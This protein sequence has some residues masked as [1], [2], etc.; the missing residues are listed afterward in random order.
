MIPNA[1]INKLDKQLIKNKIEKD[2]EKITS[3]LIKKI[4][5]IEAIFLV[6]GFG[7]DEGSVLIHNKEPY[8][9]NDYDLV[10]INH[11]SINN[12]TIESIRSE[13][14]SDLL[15]RQVDISIYKKSK[16]KKLP[17]TMYSYDLKYA[18]KLIYGDAKLLN[19]IPSMD[20]RKMPLYE[21]VRPLKLFPISLLQAYP[22]NKDLTDIDIFWSYQQISKSIIGWSTAMLVENGLYDPSYK[23]RLKLFLSHYSENNKLCELVTNAYEFKL[24][25]VHNPIDRT[26]LEKLWK[27]ANSANLD[28]TKKILGNF[29]STDYEIEKICTSI[30]FSLNNRLRRLFSFITRVDKYSITY[31][32]IGQIYLCKALSEPNEN[33]QNYYFDLAINAAHKYIIY[34]KINYRLNNEIDNLIDF[35]A[36]YNPNS[37]SWHAKG[38]KL[39]Y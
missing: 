39:E 11:K 26:N 23:K 22:F 1:M 16:L 30:N 35:F 19:L 31:I 4:P 36:S 17:Y 20:S 33:L 27:D 37:S 38:N 21:A 13:I 6:G 8:I 34:K 29:Y 24:Q 3:F 14:E 25:P 15:I 7:R 32:F 12:N 9:I 18:S 5:T 28:V 2:A 10:V